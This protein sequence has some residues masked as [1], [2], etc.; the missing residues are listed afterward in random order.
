[1]GGDCSQPRRRSHGKVGLT[2]PET[3]SAATDTQTHPPRKGHRMSLSPPP[4]P[5]PISLFAFSTIPFD[6][7]QRKVR[8]R[9]ARGKTTTALKGKEQRFPKSPFAGS[10]QPTLAMCLTSNFSASRSW[11]LSFTDDTHHLTC[12]SSV[13]DRNKQPA[14][15]RLLHTES[16][17]RLSRP[18]TSCLPAAVS[19]LLYCTSIYTPR[20]EKIREDADHHKRQR[21]DG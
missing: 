7:L 14:T 11:S 4:H 17:P 19:V 6:T 8:C 21:R 20:F 9:P 2:A 15:N 1:M 3:I 5:Q 16:R 12:L 13:R 10:P 18:P